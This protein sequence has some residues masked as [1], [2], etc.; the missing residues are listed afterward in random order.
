ML[1]LQRLQGFD[2]RVLERRTVTQSVRPVTRDPN[3]VLASKPDS[4]RLPQQ[5][6]EV[7]HRIDLFFP[8][9]IA[10]LALAHCERVDLGVFYVLRACPPAVVDLVALQRSCPMIASISAPLSLNSKPGAWSPVIRAQRTAR[11]L[12]SRWSAWRR[13]LLRSGSVSSSRV[14]C[15]GSILRSASNFWACLRR[16]SPWNACARSSSRSERMFS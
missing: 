6:W 2:D 13:L 9:G 1:G 5:P 10:H 12:P 3:Q 15:A 16:Y 4:H 14:R 11:N 8:L 7:A